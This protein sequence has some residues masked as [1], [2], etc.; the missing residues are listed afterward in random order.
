MHST[1]CYGECK[2]KPLYFYP[3]NC[4]T[5]PHLKKILDKELSKIEK[6]NA[7]KQMRSTGKKMYNFHIVEA[8]IR[9]LDTTSFNTN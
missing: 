6:V 8:F 1:K 2:R 7:N 5:G 9:D 3:Q 4:I